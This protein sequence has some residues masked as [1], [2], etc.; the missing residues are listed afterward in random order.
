MRQRWSHLLFLHWEVAAETI[1]ARLPEGLFVDTFAG[2]A[3][4]GVVPFFM[5]KVRPLPF[6]TVRGLSDFLELNLRTYVYDAQGRPGVWFFSLDCDQWLAVKIARMGFHLPYEHARMSATFAEEEIRYASLRKGDFVE[7]TFIYPSAPSVAAKPAEP[8]TLEFFLLE[9]YRLFS[10]RRDGRLYSGLVHHSPYVF[11][12]TPVND[13]STRLFSLNRFDVPGTRPVS[14][15][16]AQSV[17]IDVH[18]LE[19]VST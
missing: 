8:D 19:R 5:E 4:L 17:D 6:P 14:T 2:K 12:H 16:I 11:E 18:P 3:Y 9:R 10:A 15:L 13:F 7:Q 1:Q